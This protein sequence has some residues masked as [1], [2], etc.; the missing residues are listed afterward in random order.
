MWFEKYNSDLRRLYVYVPI[1]AAIAICSLV[2][3]IGMVVNV[4]HV[5]KVSI[6]GFCLILLFPGVLRLFEQHEHFENTADIKA[7]VLLQL[8]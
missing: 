2:V 6:V 7:N 4:I 5:R 8:V 1:G 3:L